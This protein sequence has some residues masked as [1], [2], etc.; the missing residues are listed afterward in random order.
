MNNEEN[1]VYREREIRSAYDDNL[2]KEPADEGLLTLT[3]EEISE[4][5]VPARKHFQNIRNP[6]HG[7]GNRRRK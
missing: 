3:V 7:R 2:V 1:V 5:H 6:H 4:T